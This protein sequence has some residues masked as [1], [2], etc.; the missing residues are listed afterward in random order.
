MWPQT[1]NSSETAFSHYNAVLLWD[2]NCVKYLA[3]SKS[4]FELLPIIFYSECLIIYCL[5]AKTIVFK[6]DIFLQK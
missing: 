1:F 5:I 6:I 2:L 4:F 3:Q